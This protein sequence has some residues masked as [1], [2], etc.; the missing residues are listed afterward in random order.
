[1][2]DESVVCLLD[3]A[4]QC[5]ELTREIAEPVALFATDEP[6]TGDPG[7]RL[8]EQGNS[9]D[10]RDEIGDV[11]HVDVDAAQWRVAVP[12]HGGAVV[13]ALDGTTHRTHQISEASVTLERPGAEPEDL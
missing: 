3:G 7:R 6:D 5:A 8:G 9:G 11:G 2:H 13:A 12:S 4:T 1:M 10:R